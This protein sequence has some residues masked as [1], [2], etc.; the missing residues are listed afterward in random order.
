MERVLHSDIC[1]LNAGMLEEGA[2]QGLRKQQTIKLHT[3]IK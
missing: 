3:T 1:A 2:N